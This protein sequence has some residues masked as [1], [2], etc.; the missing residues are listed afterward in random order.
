MQVSSGFQSTAADGGIQGPR[1][2]VTGTGV[3]VQLLSGAVSESSPAAALRP[4]RQKA[5]GRRRPEVGFRNEPRR[6]LL[7]EPAAPAQPGRHLSADRAA[8]ALRLDPLPSAD[9]AG[10]SSEEGIRSP[11]S[12]SSPLPRTGGVPG[13]GWPRSLREADAARAKNAADSRVAAGPRGG[14]D[15]ARL[16]SSAR[17]HFTAPAW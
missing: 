14:V 15:D 10:R 6:S 8:E 17:S 16:R 5:G 11:E 3:R 9:L 7:P 2:F 4:P 1:A 12:S 13:G